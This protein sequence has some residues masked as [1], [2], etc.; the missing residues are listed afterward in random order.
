MGWPSPARYLTSERVS[1]FLLFALALGAASWLMA[2]LGPKPYIDDAFITFR[3]AR[4]L[5]LGH[6]LTYNLDDPVLATSTPLYAFLLGF[7]GLFV[8]AEQI[9]QTAYVVNLFCVAVLTVELFWITRR[10]GLP[11]WVSGFTALLAATNERMIDVAAG[12]M[13]TPFYLAVLSGLLI[14]VDR[15]RYLLAGTLAAAL[16]LTRPE[17]GIFAVLGLSW[18]I[19]RLRRVPKRAVLPFVLITAGWVICST[20]T[21][22]AFVPQ[23]AIA[24]LS[25]GVLFGGAR[26]L[27][28]QLSESSLGLILHIW[29]GL[30]V[31]RQ[32]VG[33]WTAWLLPGTLLNLLLLGAAIVAW[34]KMSIFRAIVV[35]LGTYAVMLATMVHLAMPWYLVPVETVVVLFTCAGALKTFCD[36]AERLLSPRLRFILGTLPALVFLYATA[37]HFSLIRFPGAQALGQ[38]VSAWDRARETAYEEAVRTLEGYKGDIVVAG[39]EIGALGWY[40]RGPVLDTVGLASPEAVPYYRE[41]VQR[42]RMCA[43]SPGLVKSKRPEVIVVLEMYISECGD[44]F[45]SKSTGYRLVRKVP[46]PGLNWGGQ[47][48]L[49][50][51]R[52]DLAEGH[53]K[54]DT[55]HSARTFFSGPRFLNF[56]SGGA[57]PKPSLVVSSVSAL[58]LETK[59]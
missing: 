49:V 36:L 43:V 28:Q 46:L 16:V 57:G 40:W 23:S 54:V 13:E 58:A 42:R 18:L 55:E 7:L 41:E 5:A 31:M 25:P 44:D 32:G 9:P 53:N 38:P 3:M 47:S 20:L 48:V 33:P 35:F 21:Y 37:M 51:L 56:L 6:G 50:F 27:A 39:P 34:H 17:G 4:N 15:A 29:S 45:P 30:Y 12:G 8:G 52:E 59:I 22:G 26:I 11:C 1:T 10:L 24:K 14:A 2:R 19:Y